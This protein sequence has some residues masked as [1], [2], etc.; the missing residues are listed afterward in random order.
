MTAGPLRF[1]SR[2][3]RAALAAVLFVA[4]VSGI[5]AAADALDQ[6]LA[7][8][9]ERV[10]EGPFSALGAG[11]LITYLIANGS[12]VAGLAVTLV[13]SAAVEPARG[14]LL[15]AGSRLGA[16]AFVVLLG[17]LE[18]VRSRPRPELRRALG[19]GFLTFLV[20]I[21]VYLPATVL[22]YALFE[23]LHD[24]FVDAL[25]S[26]VEIEAL[27]RTG[28]LADSLVDA[29]GALA[30]AAIAV[31][32]VVASFQLFDEFLKGFD[33]DRLRNLFRVWLRWRW[34]SFGSGLLITAVTTSVALSVGALVPL[35]SR[36]IV[37]TRDV[38]P[39]L[40]GAGLGTMADTVLFALLL[41]SEPGLAIVLVLLA[42]AA[43]VTV[44]YL[45]RPAAY[46]RIIERAFGLFTARPAGA[47][48]FAA[49][50]LAAPG[51]LYWLG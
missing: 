28:D 33:E 47:I 51:L 21:S 8:W 10:I 14:F 41:G 23:P 26:E 3:S 2:W 25:P 29:I 22:G 48:G 9:L 45:I 36:G 15:L 27:A 20:S 46:T 4:A 12:V 30:V 24:L 42:S 38:I 6:T 50:L 44:A 18:F 37:K 19:L 16:A 13:E 40:L 43:A 11:W 39:Y 31:V 35:F 34:V 32:L 49:L 1:F 7:D 5:G 17:V